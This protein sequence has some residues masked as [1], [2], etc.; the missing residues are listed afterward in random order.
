MNVN[1]C[2]ISCSFEDGSICV[3][4]FAEQ[5]KKINFKSTKTKI[6]DCNKN[7]QINQI[8]ENQI[9]RHSFKE[10]FPY[11]EQF[12]RFQGKIHVMEGH[13]QGIT[14]LQVAQFD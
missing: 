1:S 4:D 9:K 2:E 12:I 14:S 11:R 10:I 7:K 3:I 13:K 6:I 8:F 5:A